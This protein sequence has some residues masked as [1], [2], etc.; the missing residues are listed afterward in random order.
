M[1]GET[2]I[3]TPS[4]PAEQQAEHLQAEV[5]EAREELGAL[6]GELDRR[7]HRAMKPLAV[8]AVAVAV[9]GVGSYVL[10]RLF[11]PR[12]ARRLARLKLAGR[13]VA[14]GLGAARPS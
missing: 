12:P 10:W 4:E 2:E 7:R 6:V 1:A 3:A 8:A 14:E 11:R 9:V 13:R 5:E